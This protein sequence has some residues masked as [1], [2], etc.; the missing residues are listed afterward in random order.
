MIPVDICI[1]ISKLTLSILHRE[2][3]HSLCILDNS[4]SDKTTVLKMCDTTIFFFWEV[5]GKHSKKY[6][7]EA[8]TTEL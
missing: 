5:P 7:G 2:C 4:V 8:F 1:I 6:G 3:Y